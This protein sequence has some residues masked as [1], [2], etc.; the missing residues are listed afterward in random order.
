MISSMKD[1]VNSINWTAVIVQAFAQIVVLGG[2]LVGYVITNERWKGGVDVTINNLVQLNKIQSII[3]DKLEQSID[4]LKENQ[5][6]LSQ[7]QMR[8]ATLLELHMGINNDKRSAGAVQP[9][10]NP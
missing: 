8:V 9:V 7:N 1:D 3:N 4:Q 5:L 10:P 6:V 2:L